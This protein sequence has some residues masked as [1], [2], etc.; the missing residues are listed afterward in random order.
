MRTYLR[1]VFD[2]YDS[3]LQIA[4]L[5]PSGGSWLVFALVI[6]N[7]VLGLL[8]VAFIVATSVM[9]GR[10]PGAV[11]AGVGSAE[12][13]DLV[14]AFGLAAGAFL[15]QQILAPVQAA[16]G[17]LLARRIDALVLASSEHSKSSSIF[18]CIL[19]AAVPFLLLDRPIRG[20]NTH[21]VGSDDKAIGKLATEHLIE[22]GYRRIAHIGLSSLSIGN[23]R[24]DGYKSTLK[25]HG[26]HIQAD[27]VILVESGD[28]RGEECG[29]AAMQ[30]LLML[31]PRPD[32]VFCFNDIIA[33]GA[34]KAVVE[35]GLAIPG[36]IA[37]IG[38]SNLAGL[39]FWNALQVPLSTVDQDVPKL[40]AETME[41]ILNMQSR[42]GPIAPKR[43]FVPLK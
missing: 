18:K 14:L 30:K 16:L 38:V 13:R 20:L 2:V 28:E 29:Y 4:R 37:L 23:G 9:I 35:A 36:D 43:I 27:R 42:P 17:E 39:S 34:Q 5:T 7:V 25:L 10:V 24:L 11:T 8:P 1:G 41:Q 22:R 26:S 15:A 40:A 21:F 33:S 31:D 19:D 3:Y 12:W 32:A 6:L